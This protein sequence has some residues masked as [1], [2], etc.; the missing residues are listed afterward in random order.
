MQSQPTNTNQLQTTKYLLTFPRISN[1]QYFCQKVNVPGISI[2]EITRT[3]PFVDLYVPGDKVQFEHFNISFIVDEALRSWG[4]LHDWIIDMG[5][6]ETFSQ[7]N[8]LKY[9]SEFSLNLTQP[10]Y[11]EGSL[12]ILNNLNIPAFRVDFINMFP[13]TLSGIDFD[14][15]DQNVITIIA[16]CSFRY[17][18]Y[19]ITRL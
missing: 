7:Y 14:S 5:F 11:S 16:N 4:E 8:H 18:Y 12:L 9:L 19:T 3:T 13:T 17:A 1:T 6:P 15:S 2:N 10:Q